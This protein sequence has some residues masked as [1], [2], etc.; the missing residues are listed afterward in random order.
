MMQLGCIGSDV[1]NVAASQSNRIKSWQ[2]DSVD[3]IE[4]SLPPCLL[5][6]A[7]NST[8]PPSSVRMSFMNVP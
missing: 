6:S 4:F 3:S 7:F 1:V 8:L 5:L 2:L